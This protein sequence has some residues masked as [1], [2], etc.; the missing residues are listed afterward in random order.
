MNTLLRKIERLIKECDFQGSLTCIEKLLEDTNKGNGKVDKKYL[1]YLRGQCLFNEGKY[2]EALESYS[3]AK[4]DVR[5][6]K[7]DAVFLGKLKSAIG[8][9][10]FRLSEYDKAMAELTGAFDLLRKTAENKEIAFIQN[11]YASCL[12]KTGRFD[13][14]KKYYED[15][16]SSYRRVGED[17]EIA[18]V[19]N[20]LAHISF[21]QSEWHVALN[22]LNDS[23]KIKRARK[24]YH[25]ITHQF[26]NI[27]AIHLFLG[28]YKK[29]LH[30]LRKSLKLQN[31]W[32]SE[33]SP[34]HNH[35]LLG[36][37][38][39]HQREFVKS[40]HHLT[41][42]LGYATEKDMKREVALSYE[43]LGEL[44]FE[45][46]KYE[47]AGNFFEKAR[48]ISEAI[49]PEGDVVNE[50]YRRLADLKVRIG[51]LEGARRD[52]EK[53]LELSERL[54]D[55][56]ECALAIRVMGLI[57][58][59]KG[60]REEALE[61]LSQCY[62]ILTSIG[63]KY[64]A[65]RTQ[66]EIGILLGSYKTCQDTIRKAEHH[67]RQAM[68][69]FDELG[70]NYYLAK[71]NIEIAR[72]LVEQGE[73]AKALDLLG[74]AEESFS[75]TNHEE[76]L[77]AK[78]CNI[79]RLLEE[80]M[81][82]RVLLYEEDQANWRSIDISR[83]N[84]PD[85]P[86]N[87]EGLEKL[88]FSLIVDVRADRG[89]VARRN[90]NRG[91]YK[92][93]VS[94][95]MDF[96]RSERVL[97]HFK[98]VDKRISSSKRPF[99]SIDITSDER[100]DPIGNE[101]L[102]GINSLMVIPFGLD[103]NVDGFC[104]IDCKGDHSKRPFLTRELRHVVELSNN[105]AFFIAAIERDELRKDNRYLRSQLDRKAGFDN[106]ITQDSRLLE[107]L[108]M[109]NRVKDSTIP[110]LLVG[111]TGTGKEL[112]AKA[113]H[114]MGARRDRKYIAINCA[115][116]PDNLLES[117]L[118]GHRKGA[119]TGAM[120]DKKGL[121][122]VADKG[123]FFL[124]EIAAMGNLIQVKLLRVLENGE[125]KQLGDT[126]L[127]K[128]D[129]RII[130]A[131]NKNLST[132]VKENRFREDLYY[133]LNGIKIEIPPLRERRGDIPLLVSYFI[134]K[135]SAEE[136]KEIQ[137]VTPAVLNMMM[138]YDWP[139]NV[140]ELQNEIRRVI[141]LAEDREEIKPRHLSRRLKENNLDETGDHD[142]EET[143]STLPE[144]V[145]S[146]ERNRIHSALKKTRWIKAQA[147]KELGIHEA[148]LRGKMR[149]YGIEVPTWED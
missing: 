132:E 81:V 54:G 117:E 114:Y 142:S 8:A 122:E 135:Y 105:L 58:K 16:I 62:Y 144:Q 90:G 24:Y 77:R 149:R 59:E 38:F 36:K 29:A 109:V 128:V 32:G 12:A 49:A 137:G 55:K 56:F 63:D 44:A 51:D 78:V 107:I 136:E 138:N 48:K 66:L 82:E 69:M 67:F 143:N 98:S 68:D 64:E 65:A 57:L 83:V 100:F 104:Y 129:A 115:A 1:L 20:N 61:L 73:D 43:F 6:E 27:G 50:V 103:G 13:E 146:Y 19:K 11:Y 34:V 72:L 89:F 75:Q 79:R 7:H 45:N 91:E 84:L 21:I 28:D 17:I 102:A 87:V 2:P 112:I 33:Y 93:S 147:A 133:R 118:F 125:F 86:K 113:I 10:H 139:G 40:E 99:I 52:A 145:A 85:F 127:S 141:T 95:G 31:K 124:D 134:E 5:D 76:E 71:V 30:Y 123:S 23:L 22:H 111:E 15:S 120:A 140:R 108:D 41:E 148:T 3:R 42:S 37:L 96:P 126:V 60:D 88:L 121:F 101:L 97:N 46:E 4:E 9:I 130:S 80:S 94:K 47:R 25:K 53:S 92:V 18:K 70:I 26:T 119:F 116:L 74:Y 35:L 106:I 110:V 131:T 14:A 39:L